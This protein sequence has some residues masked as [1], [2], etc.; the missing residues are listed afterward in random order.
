MVI[1][2]RWLFAQHAIDIGDLAAK[3]FGEIFNGYFLGGEICSAAT[4]IQGNTITLVYVA[5]VWYQVA[6]VLEG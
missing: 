1:D 4:Y 3:Y 6:S 5:S 2:A